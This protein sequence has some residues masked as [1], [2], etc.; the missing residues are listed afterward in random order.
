MKTK[1]WGL[2]WLVGL[3]WGTSFLW[4]KI[5]LEEVSPIVLVAF[6]SL[7]GTIG[8][9]LI[10]I[11]NKK[12]QV[13]WSTIKERLP[14]FLILGLINIALPWSLISWAEQFIDSGTAAILNGAMP[15]FTIFLSPIF[16]E[17][18]RITIPRV[19]GLV[20]GFL[21]VVILIAPSIQN[22]WSNNLLGQAASLLATFFYAASTIFARKKTQGI[23]AQTQAFLQL[24]SGTVIIWIFAFFTEKPFVIPQTPMTW[25]ALVWLGI[26]G[27]CIAYII[28][29]S[30]LHEIGPT[31]T[32]MI[33]Y[34]P[35]LIGMVLGVGFLNEQFY[36]Q[37]LV[38]ALMILSGITIVNF[39]RKQT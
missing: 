36:W 25:L 14:V 30:L 28:Y 34:I 11:I 35:P 24:A 27:S 17:D 2:F 39:K 26:L 18:D 4:I 1:D 33:T 5:A 19:V 12:V 32:S 6:R 21:G 10:I 15:L 16:I 23:P 22:K 9:G 13:T 3:I 37:A 7:F 20:I 38:G 29:F 31:R 8:L